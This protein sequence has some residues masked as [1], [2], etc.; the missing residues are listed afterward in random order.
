MKTL[1]TYRKVD[2]T[3]CNTPTV[4]GFKNSISFFLERLL[5]L[6]HINNQFYWNTGKLKSA[7]VPG[8]PVIVSA[9]I[10]KQ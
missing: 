4:F 2:T 6:P 1:A 8:A 10:Y 9:L 5:P 7:P 3:I